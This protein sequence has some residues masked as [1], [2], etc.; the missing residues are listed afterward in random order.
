MFAA[1]TIIDWMVTFLQM[2]LAAITD[3]DP[4]DAERRIDAMVDPPL[5]TATSLWF[6]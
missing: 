4:K 2:D 1:I 3:A 6:Y 5:E